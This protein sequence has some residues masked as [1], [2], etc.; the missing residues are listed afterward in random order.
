[1]E[2]LQTMIVEVEAMLNNRP[3]SY[4]SPDSEDMKP[5]T[6]SHLLLGRPIISLPHYDVQDDELT[7][8][9]YGETVD[10]SRNAK[11]HAHFACTLLAQME[12][13]NKQG[14]QVGQLLDCNHW[15]LLLQK[16]LRYE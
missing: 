11:V 14:E 6:P 16:F 3:L 4:V 7:N 13:L 15:R 8:P 10:I 2:S 1:L 5:I 12:K 9:T